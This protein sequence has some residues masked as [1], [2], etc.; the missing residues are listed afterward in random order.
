[1]ETQKKTHSLL[2]RVRLIAYWIFTGLMALEYVAAATWCFGW[3]N[4]GSYSQLMK[5]IGFP[6]YFP[7]ILGTAFLLA[8]PVILLPRLRLLKEWAYFGVAMIY[9]GGI[10]CHLYVGSE[11]KSIFPAFIFLSFTI[12]SWALRPLSRRF[13][14][15]AV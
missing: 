5:Q 8:T 13:Q 14:R 12:A 9:I 10:T 3:L 6:V 15:Y 1:M 4:K 7:Y 2:S 11:V